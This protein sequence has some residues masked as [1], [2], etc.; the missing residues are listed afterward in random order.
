MQYSNKNDSSED[1]K[2]G[3][4]HNEEENNHKTNLLLVTLLKQLI[5][6]I[7]ELT[8]NYAAASQASTP[9]RK[10]TSCSRQKELPLL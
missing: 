1:E 8:E 3:D 6:K 5:N 7:K 4:D 10:L 9:T 2:W